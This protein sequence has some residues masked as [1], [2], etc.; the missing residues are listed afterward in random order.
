MTYSNEDEVAMEVPVRIDQ[1]LILLLSTR[2]P[3]TPAYNV[4]FKD[5]TLGLHIVYE[6]PKGHR[7]SVEYALSHT[8]CYILV[9]IHI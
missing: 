8:T 3:D 6:P 4:I 2:L 7:I 9:V 1:A 5:E